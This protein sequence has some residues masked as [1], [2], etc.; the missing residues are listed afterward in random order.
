MK[1]LKLL[2]L[3]ITASITLTSGVVQNEIID[4]NDFSLN[5]YVSS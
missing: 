1:R 2:F 5:D 4:G 3:F